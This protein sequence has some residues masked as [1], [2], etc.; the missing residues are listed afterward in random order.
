MVFL[1]S[2]DEYG[3]YYESDVKVTVVNRAMDSFYPDGGEELR[4]GQSRVVLAL[5]CGETDTIAIERPKDTV[6]AIITVRAL[7][8]GDKPRT[9]YIYV[10]EEPYCNFAC[11][12]NQSSVIEISLENRP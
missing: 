10:T 4:F 9:A 5:F 12:T 1:L 3:H 11:Y 8:F 2:C 7:D 6:R